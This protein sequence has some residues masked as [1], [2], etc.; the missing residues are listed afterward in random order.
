MLQFK[1]TLST[2]NISMLNIPLLYLWLPLIFIESF[3]IKPNW[4]F[5]NYLHLWLSQFNLLFTIILFQLARILH[6]K[7]LG[8][9]CLLQYLI[10]IKLT[11]LSLTYRLH[12]WLFYWGFIECIKCILVS[13]EILEL[14]VF[15][16]RM[17]VVFRSSFRNKCIVVYLEVYVYVSIIIKVQRIVLAVLWGS[18]KSHLRRRNKSNSRLDI[19]W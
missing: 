3:S 1:G 19:S 8:R 15:L 7:L 2:K 17:V 16:L 10:Y 12:L 9:L 14:T 13:R 5:L 4:Y 6:L 18:F 11:Y